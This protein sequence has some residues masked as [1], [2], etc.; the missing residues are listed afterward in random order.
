LPSGGASGCRSIVPAAMSPR[1][2]FHLSTVR[3]AH[4]T[5]ST[6][7]IRRTNGGSALMMPWAA[8]GRVVFAV[9]AVLA[10]ALLQTWAEEQAKKS[11]E[12]TTYTETVQAVMSVPEAL[13]VLRIVHPDP[14]NVQ[15]PLQDGALR[16]AAKENFEKY[17]ARA[18]AQGEGRSDYLAGKFSA[19]Y[20]LLVDGDWDANAKA[21]AEQQL[22]AAAGS[23]DGATTG[24]VGHS[25]SADPAGQQGSGP[26]N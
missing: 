10:Q 12:E 15:V 8:L 25:S 26:R 13:E 18:Q 2:C 14:K 17:M 22:G 9:G 16:Q 23:T 4:A 5:S 3:F 20:R 21:R 6:G 1:T 19:A 11:T 7:L 24:G